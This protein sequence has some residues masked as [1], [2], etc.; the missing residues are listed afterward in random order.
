MSPGGQNS[1]F[2]IPWARTRGCFVPIFLSQSGWG[3]HS[4]DDG[5]EQMDRLPEFQTWP[6]GQRNPFG[7]YRTSE[8]SKCRLRRGL[9]GL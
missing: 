8:G 7:E 4:R 6:E 2:T 5:K 9:L 3:H 1:F